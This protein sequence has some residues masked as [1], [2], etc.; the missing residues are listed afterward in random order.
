MELK[1]KLQK[2][3]DKKM[4]EITERDS[5]ISA[6]QAENDRDNAFIQGVQESIKAIPDELLCTETKR[7]Q[8][9]SRAVKAGSSSEKALTALRELGKPTHINE[10]AVKMGSSIS[11]EAIKNIASSL[12]QSANNERIFTRPAPNT[13]GLIEWDDYDPDEFEPTEDEIY[14]SYRDQAEEDE[15]VMSH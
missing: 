8:S 6:L 11:Q 12:R 15:E 9:K 2:Q 7:R 3:I 10:L 4:A 5:Q 14:E 13:F 1:A